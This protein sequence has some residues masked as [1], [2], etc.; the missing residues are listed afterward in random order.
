M[1]KTDYYQLLGVGKDADDASIKRAFRKMAMKYHPD[2]NPDNAEAEKKFKEI[3]EAYEVLKDPQKRSAYDQYGHAAFEQGGPGGG[4]FQGGDFGGF[5]DVFEDLFSEFMGGGG[6]GRRGN[7]PSRGSD[8]R[9]N[10]TI[11]LEDAFHGRKMS[12][13]VP[14][15]VA[16]D[17]CHGN[18]SADGSKPVNC[19]TCQGAGKVRAQQGFFTIERTC[20]TC[21]GQG[22]TV[23]NPCRSC[24]GQG[25]VNK[26]RSLSVTIPKG[27]ESGQRIR[28]AGEGE[29]GMRGGAAGDLYIFLDIEPHTLFGRDGQDLYCEVP[30]PMTTAALGGSVEIPSLDGTK[31]KITI[32][33]GTQTGKKFRLRGKGMPILRQTRMG[34]LYVAVRV[35][36]PVNLT[37]KQRELLQE[38]AHVGS[39][40]SPEHQGFFDRVRE[41]FTDTDGKD[42]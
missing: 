28:L 3:N 34:D 8:L 6:R 39:N 2:Q 13:R 20:P 5:G 17:S 18:G 10:L 14:G 36:T 16:C 21:Q 26:E 9:Y 12:I 23:K 7:G 41:F 1:A 22:Q 30:V 32:P 38:F 35:E 15:S 31:G 29:A 24:R 27:V 25:R 40:N 42:Q 37:T 33:A 4:G 11:S 19:P